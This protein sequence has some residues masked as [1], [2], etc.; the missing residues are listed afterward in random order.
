MVD[1]SIEQLVRIG[2][3]EYEAKAYI[4]LLE[5]NPATGYH[6]AKVSGVPRSMVYEVL[7]KLVSRGA[8]MTVHKDGGTEYAPVPADEFLEQLHQDHEELITSLKE[9]LVSLGST[10]D[11]QYVWNI[12]G[13]ENVITKAEEMIAQAAH[14]IY[15]ATLPEAFYDLEDLLKGAIDRGVRVVV[16]S[17][18][19]FDLPGGR[20]VAASMSEEDLRKTE[21]LGLVLVIDGDEV[22]VG[23]RLGAMQARAS[24][25]SNSLFVLIA[26]HHLRTDLYLPQILDLLGDRALEVIHEDDRELFA[27][28]FESHIEC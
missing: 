27:S 11:M 6:I 13:H 17:S 12:E 3:S 8:A 28:A 9:E 2:F 25:T 19:C 10:S 1:G 14:T 22:L 7:G 15:M 16:Y 20:V 23:E 26:E 5:E 18:R 4:A 24:W 21:G